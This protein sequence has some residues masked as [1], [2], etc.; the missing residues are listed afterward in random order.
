M[1]ELS[2]SVVVPAYNSE[3]TIEACLKSILNQTIAVQ[4]I[5]VVDD[6]STDRTAEIIQ[7]FNNVTYI[8]QDNAGPAV[9]RNRGLVSLR[10]ILFFLPMQT[11]I[12][13]LIGSNNQC[14]ILR[15]PMWRWLA[16][17]M[18]LRILIRY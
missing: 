13:R 15:K 9:A 16:V 7:S 6:G 12:P 14:R 3:G 11:V 18:G 8:Y 5:I 4:Q 17:A 2:V 10:L 1:S